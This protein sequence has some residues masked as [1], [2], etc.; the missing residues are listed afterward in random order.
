MIYFDW[1]NNMVL[2]NCK[3]KKINC[4]L[5]CVTFCKNKIT[6]SFL[7]KFKYKSGKMTILELHDLKQAYKEATNGFE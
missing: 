2:E 4:K 6:K 7:Y 5:Y 3:I 1:T